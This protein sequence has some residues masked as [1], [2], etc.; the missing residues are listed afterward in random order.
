MKVQKY[1][2]LF[3]RFIATEISMFEGSL[4]LQPPQSQHLIIC[5][6]CDDAFR[7]AW[8]E[9]YGKIRALVGSLYLQAA[10]VFYHSVF[11][12]SFYVL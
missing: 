2:Q 7:V 8:M 9:I 11:L 6:Y 12:A 4:H 5:H 10:V 3:S 1:S